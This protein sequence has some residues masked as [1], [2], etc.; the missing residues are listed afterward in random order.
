MKY[1]PIAVR[2][3]RRR[4]INEATDRGVP[5]LE[6]RRKINRASDEEV[7]GV[8]QAEC[9]RMGVAPPMSPPT[10]E[11]LGAIGDGTIIRTIQEFCETH[12]ELIKAITAALLLLVGL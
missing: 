11:G 12:P 8:I 3:A 1:H 9:V 10:S 2:M 5:W 7:S 6:A 4:A